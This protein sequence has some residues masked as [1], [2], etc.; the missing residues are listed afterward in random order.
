MQ[1]PIKELRTRELRRQ[2]PS[3]RVLDRLRNLRRN[4]PVPST[5]RYRL[6]RLWNDT[7]TSIGGRAIA[8]A[9]VVTECRPTQNL[10]RGANSPDPAQDSQASDQKGRFEETRGGPF[11][12]RLQKKPQF[13]AS[14]V[15]E[16]SI[17]MMPLTWWHQHLTTKGGD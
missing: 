6:S 11:A 9:S 7:S 2:V 10:T 13:G 14:K 15:R 4:Q 8:L 5:T 16:R 12:V 17:R 3:R 1:L